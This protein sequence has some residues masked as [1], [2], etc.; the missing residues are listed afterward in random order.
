MIVVMQQLFDIEYFVVFHLVLALL[1]PLQRDSFLFWP[2]LLSSLLIALL[3]WLYWQHR[4]ALPGWRS[5]RERF[6]SAKLWWH[7]SACADYRLYFTNALLFPAVFGALLFNHQEVAAWLDGL[8]GYSRNDASTSD[9]SIAWK[10]SY[11]L[12]FFVA[13]DFGRFVS[14]SL[15]HDV[16][17]LW[18]FHKVHHSAEVLTPLTA[19]RVHPVDLL[20]MAWG[21]TAATGLLAWGFNHLAGATIDAYLFMGI[22]ALLW[23]SNLIGN[24]NHTS[25]WINYGPALGKWLISPAHHQVHHSSETRHL[26]CNRGFQL[27]IWDRLYGTLYVPVGPEEQFNIGLDD[28]TSNEWHNVRHMLIHPFIGAARVL[29]RRLQRAPKP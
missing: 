8:L 5:I 3:S 25:V 17:L 27:A 22:H 12:L 16:P 20:L 28:R 13:Y 1:A 26:G 9:V 23:V 21:G 29:L 7:R 6:F 4:Q 19:F 2:F 11:T 18:E 14:H 10:L 24:L 15:L